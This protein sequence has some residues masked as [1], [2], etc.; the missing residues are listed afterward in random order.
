MTKQ[1]GLGDG[2]YYNGHDLSGDTQA[3]SRIGGG[4]SPLE[5]TGIDKLAFERQGGKR[6][7][8][9][10]L[11]SFFNDTTGQAH[12]TYSALPTTDAILTY[13]RGVA[14]GSPAFCLNAKQVNYDGTRAEDGSL[15]FAVDSL[16]NGFGGEWGVQLAAKQTVTVDGGLT[17]IDDGAQTTF[18]AQAY[19]QLFDVTGTGV[20]IV[21]EDSAD[22]VSFSTIMTFSGAEISGASD[23]TAYRATKT[24]NVRRYT[25]VNVTGDSLTSATFAVVLCRNLTAVSF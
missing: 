13:C 20:T 17:A 10:T 1:T 16:A 23:P 19:L 2:F 14:L 5:M 6:D 21:V 18:G 8:Q 25:R 22:N 9:I 11:A 24:G 7:G 4:N 15:I 12:P 3:F